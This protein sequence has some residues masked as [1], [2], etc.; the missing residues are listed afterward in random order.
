MKRFIRG[1]LIFVG[2]ILLAYIGILALNYLLGN[3]RYSALP[4][5]KEVAVV[6]LD[7][8]IKD[9]RWY[10]KTFEKLRKDDSVK[11]I[12]FRVDSPGGAVVPSQEL[13]DEIKRVVK[14]KPVVVSMGSVA[15][16]GGLYV[17]LPATEIV[18]DPATITGSIGV[19]LETI[20][21]SKLAQKLGI[22]MV[23]VKS[24]KHKDLLNPFRPPTEG[25]LKI[26]QSV[27]NDT[28]EQFV[29]AVSK[30][31]NIPIDKVRKFADGRIFTGRQAKK[32]GLVD[33]LGDLHFAIE[34]AKRLSNCPKAKVVYIKRNSGLLFGS[35]SI[36]TVIKTLAKVLNGQLSQSRLMFIY[37]R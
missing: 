22:N 33:K 19:L 8:V 30:S 18:A 4:F 11:A 32:I 36:L 26:V 15:A 20:N 16:S 34:E 17:S 14:D 23:V 3:Q 13:Y 1:M 6:E 12:V 24:S 25:D 10:I 29:E 21:I 35:D 7:G 37:G 31:R 28:Y 5:Q 9:T 2:V 27:V